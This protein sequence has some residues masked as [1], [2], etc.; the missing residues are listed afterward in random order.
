MY[1]KEW[2]R[3][4][5]GIMKGLEGHIEDVIYPQL[6]W[7]EFQKQKRKLFMSCDS[8]C[9]DNSMELIIIVSSADDVPECETR[10]EGIMNNLGYALVVPK[11][12]AHSCNDG[13]I[14]L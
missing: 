2:D 12:L 9:L 7:Q 11:T 13:P 6:M 14:S 5:S 8:D 10:I 1:Q 3:L 4:K